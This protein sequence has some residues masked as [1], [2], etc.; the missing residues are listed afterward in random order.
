MTERERFRMVFSGGPVDRPPL[1][2]EGVR[3][4]VIDLWRQQGMPAG[5]THLE[6]FGLTPHERVGPDITARP[7]CRGRIM[8]LSARGFRRAYDVS[9]DRFPDDWEKTARRL[10]DRTHIACVWAFRGFFQALGV[11]DWATL[12]PVLYAVS[13]HPGKV[14]DRLRMYAEFCARMLDSA[15]RDVEPEFI[16]L[17]E[18]IS[19]SNGPLISPK[20]FRSF[21]IPAYE[22]VIAV[23]R[24]HGVENILVS[25]YGNSAELLPAMIGAGV[26]ILWAS[27]V[28]ETPGMDYRRLRERHGARLGLVG[29]VPLGILRSESAGELERRL[30]EIVP[31]LLDSGRFIPLAAGRVREKVPWLRYRRYREV[32]AD[33]IGAGRRPGPSG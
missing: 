25:T 27:E 15:L 16:Y 32:L 31:P 14:R 3:E 28:S 8:G 7:D 12:E 30:R 29:G 10:A 17:G 21:A 24:R 6:I 5:R 9:R 23:A 18:P 4:G 11:G 1:L 2:E 26:N 13:D 33:L 20:M 22:K 19:D